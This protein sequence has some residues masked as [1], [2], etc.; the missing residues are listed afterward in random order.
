MAEHNLHSIAFPTLSELKSAT[1]LGARM[2]RGG[3]IATGRPFLPSATVTSN[4]SLFS[5][6]R[7]Q[8]YSEVP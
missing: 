5:P 7:E 4:S 6:G 2:P 1:C 8:N 3:Y